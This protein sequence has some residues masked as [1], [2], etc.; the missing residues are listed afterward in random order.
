MIDK[1]LRVIALAAMIIAAGVL[2]WLIMMLT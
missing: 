2:V 1:A